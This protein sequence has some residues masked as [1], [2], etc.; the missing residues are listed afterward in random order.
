MDNE[1]VFWDCCDSEEL[2]HSDKD[3]AIEAFLDGF[4]LPVMKPEDWAAV[5][6]TIEVSGY[7][8]AKV[9]RNLDGIPLEHILELLDEDYGNPDA[10]TKPTKRMKEAEKEFLKVV[11]EEYFVWNCEKVCKEEVNTMEWILE[12]NPEWLE[13]KESEPRS[14]ESHPYR[15][16]SEWLE[17][18]LKTMKP[19]ELCAAKRVQLCHKCDDLN[20]RDNTSQTYK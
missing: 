12:N 2:Y 8:R 20:C 6:K 17:E 5:P 10:E 7:V 16:F 19:S 3:E 18:Q 13:I 1:I 11:L 14:N 4:M 15:E 9:D